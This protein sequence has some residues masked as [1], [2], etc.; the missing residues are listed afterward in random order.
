MCRNSSHHHSK[1]TSKKWKFYKHLR[2]YLIVNGIFF[3]IFLADGEAHEWWQVAYYWGIGL[4]IH[5]LLVFRPWAT[6]GLS[7]E[8]ERQN[9]RELPPL[10]AEQRERSARR[11]RKKWDERDLV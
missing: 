3:F 9:Q 10:R 6:P 1:P 2:A 7:R 5:Y 8:W 11:K 4:L